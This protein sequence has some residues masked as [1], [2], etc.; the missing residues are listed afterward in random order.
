MS[1]VKLQCRVRLLLLASSLALA[2]LTTQAQERSGLASDCLR[3]SLEPTK[4][5][6]WMFAGEWLSPETML[7]VDAWRFEVLKVDAVT[8]AISVVDLPWKAELEAQ[9]QERLNAR[10]EKEGLKRP[11]LQGPVSIRS[12]GE[13][14]LFEYAVPSSTIALP[15]S[16]FSNGSR[17][18]ALKASVETVR[19]SE[20]NVMDSLVAVSSARPEWTEKALSRRP[21]QIHSTY[22]MVE[23]AGGHLAFASI[24]FSSSEGKHE[25]EESIVFVEGDRFLDLGADL[26]RSETP[27]STFE[28][29]RQYHLVYAPYLAEA[30]DV[31]FALRLL[32]RPRLMRY[33]PVPGGRLEVLPDFPADFGRPVLRRD[34]TLTVFQNDLNDYQELERTDLAAGIYSIDERLFLLG[35]EAMLKGRGNWW[36]VELDTTTGREIRRVQLPV[37]HDAAHLTPV[38][39][40]GTVSFVEKAAVQPLTRSAPY[41]QILS[42]TQLPTSW[43]TDAR[44]SPLS[45]GK[46]IACR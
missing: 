25:F 7:W 28:E 14:L 30:G 26:R 32:E 4:T 10:V 37:R 22:Q 5:P 36:A 42:M 31:G 12:D 17:L 39:G 29:R 18:D 43:L 23:L 8:G 2:A 11:R 16:N 40:P 33:V 24:R 34:P 21:P 15:V 3:V 19:A 9:W 27:A 6:M 13:N 35:R 41:L 20:V 45:L 1:R 44:Q 38:I 46:P